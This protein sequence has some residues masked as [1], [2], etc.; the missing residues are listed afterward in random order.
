MDFAFVAVGIVALLL[1][2]VIEIWSFC[3][4][5][6]SRKSQKWHGAPPLSRQWF[7]RQCRQNDIR[8][9]S[10]RDAEK[11]LHDAVIR[12]RRTG[13]A[14][15]FAWAGESCENAVVCLVYPGNVDALSLSIET[16][17]RIVNE[18]ESSLSKPVVVDDTCQSV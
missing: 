4:Q 18:A 13:E 14:Q 17:L 10:D 15:V 2:V 7:E 9:P 5:R 3:S 16:I 11:M 8:L 12:Y 1:A 6:R